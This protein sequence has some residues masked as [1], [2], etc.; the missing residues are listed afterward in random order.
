[1]RERVKL[2]LDPSNSLRRGGST[3]TRCMRSDEAGLPCVRIGTYHIV[4]DWNMLKLQSAPLQKDQ[5][6]LGRTTAF[7]AA[8]RVVI[9][10]K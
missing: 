10:Q 3:L 9:G 2:C 6:F 1:M 4:L 8:R 5:T 7:V